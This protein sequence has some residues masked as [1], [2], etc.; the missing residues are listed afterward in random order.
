MHRQRDTSDLQAPGAGLPAAE[1]LIAHMGLTAYASIAAKGR[2]LERFQQEAKRA[3][4]LVQSM[5]T[6]VEKR[7]VLIPRPMG[8]EDSSRNWSAAMTLEH[9]VIV[10]LGIAGIIKALCDE[11]GA[12]KLAEVRIE[13]V[14]PSADAGKEQIEGLTKAVAAYSETIGGLDS[15]RTRLRHPH[16]WFGPLDARGWHALAAVHNGLHRRQIEIIVDRLG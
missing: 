16:P 1:R 8:I 7:R 5:A 14:K 9:L 3:I 15:L 4:S 2:V 10:N 13:N 12:R 6:D 11:D